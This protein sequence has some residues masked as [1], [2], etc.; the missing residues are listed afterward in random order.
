MNP[1]YQEFQITLPDGVTQMKFFKI[2]LKT[3]SIVSSFA[4]S[5]LDMHLVYKMEQL[6]KLNFE[7]ALKLSALLIGGDEQVDNSLDIYRRNLIIQELKIHYKS[8][9]FINMEPFTLFQ[10]CNTERCAEAWSQL[11]L[12]LR[13]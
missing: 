2:Q 8:T 11:W 3:G 9:N 12:G 5:D 1:A 10:A 7:T 4:P 6:N 13:K